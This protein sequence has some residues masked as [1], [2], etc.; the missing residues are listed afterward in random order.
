MPIQCQITTVNDE[1]FKYE[2]ESIIAF[3]HVKINLSTTIMI[4]YF[5]VLG[6]ID[7]SPKFR[8]NEMHTNS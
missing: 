7:N 6:K 5:F 2:A 8:V 3:V 1:Q 4:F